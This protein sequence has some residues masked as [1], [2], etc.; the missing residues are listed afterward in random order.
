MA[1]ADRVSGN[2]DANFNS[3]DRRSWMNTYNSVISQIRERVSNGTL[4]EG[5]LRQRPADVNDYFAVN[6]QAG[7]GTPQ[8]SLVFNT[9][10]L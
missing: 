6:F 7:V 9:A 3:N 5:I 10:N 8:A 4:R 2:I 1:A